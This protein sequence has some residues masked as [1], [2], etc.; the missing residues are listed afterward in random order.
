MTEEL[1][2]WSAVLKGYSFSPPIW[3]LY[4]WYGGWAFRVPENNLIVG[5]RETTGL[6]LLEKSGVD[7]ASVP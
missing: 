6:I 7:R 3:V 2:Q 5:F 4:H 1:E